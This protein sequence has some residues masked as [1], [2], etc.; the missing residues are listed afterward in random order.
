MGERRATRLPTI[1]HRCVREARRVLAGAGVAGE[2]VLVGVSGGGDS[3]ALLEIAGLLAPELRL[4]LHVACVDHALRPE[5][6]DEVELVRRAA[7]RWSAAFHEVRLEGEDDDEDTLRRARHAALEDVR[8][9]AGCRVLLLGHTRDDQI[10]TIVFRFLR[11]AG[12]GGLAGMAPV[13]AI[14]GEEGAALVRPLLAIARADLRRVLE[15]RDVAWAEDPT[16]ES[17]RYARGRLRTTVLPAVEAAFGR[18]ALD[19]LLDLA[20]RWRADEG[21]LEREAARHLAYASRRVDGSVALDAAALAEAHPAMRARVLRLWLAERSGRSPTSRE[22]AAI[23]RWLATSAAR[24]GH[25]D[26]PG[27]RLEGA[28]GRI[29]LV[30]AVD[31][32]ASAIE[33]R[34]ASGNEEPVAPVVRPDADEVPCS[35]KAV[36]PPS[37]ARVRVPRTRGFL[38]EIPRRCRDSAAVSRGRA[39]RDAQ[40][41]KPNE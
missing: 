16:N 22:I 2:P 34:V 14:E 10:E 41:L 5:S 18:G 4:T 7:A 12:L 30:Q 15:A 37:E 8:L 31:A 9:A 39:R 28:G 40:G 17:P 29:A 23:E 20:P 1:V 21:F 27:A 3:M 32:A 13:R 35:A 38:Q 11:G 19:H 36:L 26:L 6:R 33:D 24:R 25:L